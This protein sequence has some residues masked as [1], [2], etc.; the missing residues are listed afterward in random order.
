MM[1]NKKTD[2]WLVFNTADRMPG[3]EECYMLTTTNDAPG[4][5]KR[6]VFSI[7]KAEKQD[8]FGSDDI[9]RY[10]QKV[11]LVS[12]PYAFKKD[13]VL[14]STPK[15]TAT[16]SP[17]SRL[18]EASM[19][20]KDT[21]LG[22]WIIDWLDPNDRLEQQGEPV[23]ASDPVLLRHCQTQHYLASDKVRYASTFGGENEVSCHSHALL[24]KT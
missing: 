21:Y 24:N 14:A 8:I 17:V 11:K 22:Q 2:G 18:Q 4:P 23:R 12:N 10:G 15:G 1:K 13:L 5:V 19:H 20:S 16:Y 9:I 6:S 7:V 3:V